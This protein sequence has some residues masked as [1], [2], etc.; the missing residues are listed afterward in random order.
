M[1]YSMETFILWDKN[2]RKIMS[3]RRVIFICIKNHLLINGNSI[4]RKVINDMK[5]ALNPC[6]QG[7]E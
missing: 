7:N 4:L 6:G 5:T 3:G 2:G 1:L